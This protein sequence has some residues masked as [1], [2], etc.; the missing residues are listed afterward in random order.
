MK[1]KKKLLFVMNSLHVGG[2]EKALISMLQIID[3][4]LYE[5]DLQLFQQKGLFMNQ[6]PAEVNILPEI[7]V[8]KFYDMPGNKAAVRLFTS[9]KWITLK[10]RI[11]AKKN[12]FATDL[13]PAVKEQML[14]K[15]LSPS[16]PKS[17]VNYDASISFLEKIPCYYIVDKITARKKISYVQNDYEK[18][19][20]DRD[21]DEKYF[22]A[23]DSIATCS[24]ECKD[25][26]DRVFP[27]KKDK[28]KVIE[29]IVSPKL[30]HQMSLEEP[31][32][33]FP[34]S[35]KFVSIGRVDTRKG[36]DLSL[37][38]FKI[39][40]K[41]GIDFHWIILGEG[42]LREPL[43]QEIEKE[44]MQDKVTFVGVKENHYPYL[45]IADVFLH[46]SRFEGKSLAIEEAKI[47]AKPILV[48]NFSTVKDQIED[49][50]TGLIA[51]MNAKDI[52]RN[53]EILLNESAVRK[54]LSL[55]LKA[56]KLGTEDEVFKLYQLIEN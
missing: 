24:G 34:D 5:V 33:K 17:I 14:W 48:T 1:M 54:E 40:N 30:I 55:N 46:T 4:S 6:I 25:I 28:I 7:E 45:R 39:I 13:K 21:F 9:G 26:L 18:L 47:M 29:N 50:K 3:Y 43:W 31:A 49:G 36:Y 8:F 51:E 23:V 19:G 35:L 44:G 53:L 12:V 32:E 38:A 11:L 37:D 41:T 56:Q 2:A 20:M 22:S 15:Y 42:R 10:N 52:A 16:V 27:D